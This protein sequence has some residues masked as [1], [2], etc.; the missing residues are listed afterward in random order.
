VTGERHGPPQEHQRNVAARPSP[1]DPIANVID[2]DA[3]TQPSGVDRFAMQVLTRTGTE[4]IATAAQDWLARFETALAAPDDVLLASL[5]LSDSY[6]RDVLALT[7]RI[8]TIVG[9]WA[10]VSELGA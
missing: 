6:W 9:T 7:W 8:R 2:W 1:G 5:F 3:L 4:T 10:I